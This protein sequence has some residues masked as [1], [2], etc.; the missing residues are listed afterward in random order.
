M[1]PWASGGMGCA[2][3]EEE[4]ENREGDLLPNTL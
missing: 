3:D 4:Q 2:R 1:L